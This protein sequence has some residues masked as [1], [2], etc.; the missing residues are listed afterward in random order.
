ML[1]SLCDVSL[2]IVTSK[3]V[4]S[5]LYHFQDLKRYGATTV[6]RVCDVTYDKT[7]LEK[8]GITVVVSSETHT[9]NMNI[10]SF[11]DQI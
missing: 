1:V 5:S 6:V 11:C 3:K 9:F 8:D 4:F 10:Y 2:C 7:R